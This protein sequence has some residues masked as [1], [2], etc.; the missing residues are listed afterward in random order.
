M[1]LCQT[2]PVLASYNK[3]MIV[4]QGAYKTVTEAWEGYHS[5][6]L[7]KESSK[8]TTFVTP[9]GLYRYLTNP[10][11]NHVSGDAYNK[12]FHEVTAGFRKVHRQVDD[13]LLWDSTVEAC[14][15]CTAEYLTLL[16][17][18]GI[19]KNPSFVSK[20]W[21]GQVLKLQTMGSNQWHILASPSGT[22]PPQSTGR[23]C[24]HS[25]HSL[26]KSPMLQLLHPDSSS[27]GS[28]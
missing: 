26:T 21:T 9:F 27:S 10:Q 15:R 28:F 23:T 7:G 17:N 24:G 2:Q 16:G 19:L 14:F 20:R 22:S 13:S 6:H 18:N 11:G 4:P 12:Q 8:L 1:T 5:I 25:W 3:A